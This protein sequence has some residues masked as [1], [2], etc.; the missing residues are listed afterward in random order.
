M[1]IAVSS[2]GPSLQDMV[3][4]RFGRAAGFVIVDLETGASQY[5][6]NGRGQMLGHGAGIQAAE[7][8]ARAGAQVLLTGTVGPKAWQALS[9][10]GINIVQQME[11]L[12]VGQAI[13]QFKKLRGRTDLA[14]GGRR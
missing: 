13:E 1:K 11:G 7:T 6:D 2:N 4:P 10:A 12:T 3:D 14:Q 9:A 8:I 5:L